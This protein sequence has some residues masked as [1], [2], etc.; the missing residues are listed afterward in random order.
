MDSTTVV[1]MNA[2]RPYWY[3]IVDGD[4]DSLELVRLNLNG[5]KEGIEIIS[6]KN[7]KSLGIEVSEG[8]F[9]LY[10]GKEKI[11][12]RRENLKLLRFFKK[13]SD[14]E[15]KYLEIFGQF[16]SQAFRASSKDK[17]ISNLSKENG[18]ETNDPV[19]SAF[20]DYVYYDS[21]SVWLYNDI[22]NVFTR[23]S[24]DIPPVVDHL[25]S[26]KSGLLIEVLG[27]DSPVFRKINHKNDVLV[28]KVGDEIKWV[29]LFPVTA[30]TTTTDNS[31]TAVVCMY[32]RYIEYNLRTNTFELIN[33]F[34][35]Q[36]LA[37]RYFSRIVHLN[38]A[39]SQIG[40]N[41]KFDSSGKLFRMI[42]KAISEELMWETCS[43]YIIDENDLSQ[44][45]QKAIWPIPEKYHESNEIFYKIN[46]N[47]MTA[48]VFSENAILCSYDIQNDQRNSHTVDDQTES[49]PYDWIGVPLSSPGGKPLGVLRVKN[50]KIINGCYTHFCSLDIHNLK[51][52]ASEV[53]SILHQYNS[54]SEKRKIADQRKRE[55]EEQE[56]F[57]KTFRHEIRSPIQAVCVAPDMISLL[58]RDEL[59]IVSSEYPKKFREY[60]A[61]FKATGNRLE[62]ISK[63]L[64]LDPDEI[65]KELI[66]CNIFKRCLAPVLAFTTPHA[67]KK[68][69]T[70]VVDKDSLFYE[71]VCDKLA[72]SIAFHG[73][74]DNAIKYSDSGSVINVYGENFK[75]G[76]R[77]IVENTTSTFSI[78][79]AESTKLMQKYVRGE[80]AKEQK[81]EGSGIGLFLAKRIMELHHGDVELLSI[82]SP[83]R[84]ALKFRN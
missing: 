25:E 1:F 68:R 34:H 15:V 75:N 36:Y 56:D 83:I 55:L 76:L 41:I 72:I 5:R 9:Q 49:A 27:A 81:L 10:I 51:A 23:I 22:T 3:K 42:A 66:M 82:T 20:R 74:I 73:L 52:I 32:S 70:I 8:N 11:V 64:T 7:L 57:L 47:A 17:L 48:R 24:G 79:K 16:V 50:R 13:I 33:A 37:H 43:I 12:L 14:R 69:R 80:K 30:K 40:R 46:S 77:V 18:D 39:R 67:Q 60:L 84:F 61:D 62:L 21:Y 71:Y 59:K 65:V 53:T 78:S 54:F 44:L 29:N 28:D 58:L 35:Q 2:N 19:I 4:F 6:S 26:S 31:F 63:S 45:K 38:N